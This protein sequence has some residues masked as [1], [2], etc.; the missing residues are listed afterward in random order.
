MA[1]G[2]GR[3]FVILN[4]PGTHPGTPWPLALGPT[5]RLPAATHSVEESRGEGGDRTVGVSGEN[6]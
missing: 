6:F 3:L 2:R 5:H 1:P 4:V